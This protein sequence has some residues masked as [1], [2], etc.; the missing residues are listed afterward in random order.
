VLKTTC[1]T[2]QITNYGLLPK[3]QLNQPDFAFFGSDRLL[4]VV[5]LGEIKGLDGLYK[6]ARPQDAQKRKPSGLNVLH[7]L[8]FMPKLLLKGFLDSVYINKSSVM[9]RLLALYFKLWPDF[10]NIKAPLH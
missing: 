9:Y 4:Q 6:S 8:H 7:L 3:C 5:D 10:G 1:A 2:N